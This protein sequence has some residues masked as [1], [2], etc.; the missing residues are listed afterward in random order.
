MQD[1]VSKK[2]ALKKLQRDLDAVGAREEPESP[3]RTDVD[4]EP[5]PISPSH[6]DNP[7]NDETRGKDPLSGASP[8]VAASADVE[9]RATRRGQHQAAPERRLSTAGN[10]G[11]TARW[12]IGALVVA[13]VLWLLLG[14]I[15]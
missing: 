3:L 10:P 9:A 12:V 11:K 4:A 8:S 1:Q 5:S 7:L 13:L 6:P 15:G 14:W 2:A